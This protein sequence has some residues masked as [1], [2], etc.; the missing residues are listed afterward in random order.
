MKLKV[1]IKTLTIIKA[2]KKKGM[3]PMK[4]WYNKGIISLVAVFLL[5]GL[6]GCGS[7]SDKSSNDAKKEDKVSETTKPKAK[8]KKGEEVKLETHHMEG[9]Y[10][11][12]A[13]IVEV[14]YTKY[15]EVNYKSTVDGQEVKNH[16]WV[17]Q[18]EIKDNPS[19]LKP[20]DH[21][22]LEAD[23]MKGMKGAEATIDAVHEGFIYAVDYHPTNDTSKEVKDHK[24]VTQDE[25]TKWK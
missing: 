7:S 17:V 20:G 23:H 13:K 19:N 4:K 21:V 2:D 22:T 24:W 6:A 5:F 16:K 15:Y 9:M 3:I 18:D 11:A 8:F 14:K 12:K 25:M 1:L 10:G